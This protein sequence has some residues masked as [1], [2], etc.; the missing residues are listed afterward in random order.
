MPFIPTAAQIAAAGVAQMSY[1]PGSDSLANQS[2]SVQAT[3]DRVVV[4]NLLTQ[5][6]VAVIFQAL[7]TETVSGS[8]SNAAIFVNGTQLKDLISDGVPVVQEAS[9]GGGLGFNTPLITY[10]AGLYSVNPVT[11]SATLATPHAVWHTG[12][13]GGICLIAPGQ[14]GS[15]T[16]DV[17]FK[18]NGAGLNVRT[19]SRTLIAWQV[20]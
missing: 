12:G 17:R 3:P 2:Y 10:P 1:I 7:W 15:C 18:A 9:F 13:Q 11:Q 8:S 4:P 16:I 19:S 5:S 6:I 14:A 20:A